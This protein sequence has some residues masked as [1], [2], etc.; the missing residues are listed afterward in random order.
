MKTTNGLKNLP[1]KLIT[2]L[3]ELS[4]DEKDELYAWLHKDVMMRKWRNRLDRDYVTPDVRESI[5]N[6]VAQRLSEI[7]KLTDFVSQGD[8]EEVTCDVLTDNGYIMIKNDIETTEGL[9]DAEINVD[10]SNEASV[11]VWIEYGEGCYFDEDADT[12]HY[13]VSGR[14]ENDT[15]IINTENL[16]RIYGYDSVPAKFDNK[17][18]RDIAYNLE[19]KAKQAK[20]AI[21][22]VKLIN[23]SEVER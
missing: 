13:E 7:Y 17:Q 12:F 21:M 16:Q 1:E 5:L 11:F 15:L 20:Q 14:I 10:A 2:V 18:I 8:V 19:V 22:N 9:K 4:L 23:Y 6:Q 3:E